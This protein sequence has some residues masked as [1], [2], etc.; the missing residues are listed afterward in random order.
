MGPTFVL[1]PQKNIGKILYRRVSQ[2]RYNFAPDAAIITLFFDSPC[3]LILV[4]V[5][6]S[7]PQTSDGTKPKTYKR[8]T[9][10]T[11]DQ[12][13]RQTGTNVRLVQTLD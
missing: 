2:K 3:I 11:S 6:T 1:V 9:V 4:P 12:Y 7:D 8:R 10:Q 13:K 5:Q